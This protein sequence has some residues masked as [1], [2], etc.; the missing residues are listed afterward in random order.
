MLN[1]KNSRFSLQD[2]YVKFVRHFMKQNQFM[3]RKTTNGFQ[4]R[5]DSV[6]CCFTEGNRY[7]AHHCC[8][9]TI[10]QNWVFTVSSLYDVILKFFLF[11]SQEPLIY[12][13]EQ[14]PGKKYCEKYTFQYHETGC[15]KESDVED[16]EV[17]CSSLVLTVI[18]T[19][20]S[21]ANADIFL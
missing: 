11:C 2:S 9:C 19:G 14:L 16:T 12:L 7:P 10:H 21:V 5:H 6:L 4:M 18:D 17:G 13:I 15:K 8:V 1:T 20:W 3:K